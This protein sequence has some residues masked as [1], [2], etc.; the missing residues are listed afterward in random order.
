MNIKIDCKLTDT[1]N[2]RIETPNGLMHQHYIE[3]TGE[4]LLEAMQMLMVKQRHEN[5]SK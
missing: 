2:I 3:C 1:F 4:E 5:N